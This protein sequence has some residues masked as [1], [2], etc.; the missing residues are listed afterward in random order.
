MMGQFRL[1]GDEMPD[2]PGMSAEQKSKMQNHFDSLPCFTEE[3]LSAIQGMLR[4][5]IDYITV[6]ELAVLKG[7]RLRGEIDKYIETHIFEDIKLPEMAK[8]L[9]RSIS[10]I[11]QFLRKNY[12]TTF[13][14]LV[15]ENRLQLAENY[16]RTHPHATV[17]EVAYSAGF[18]DQFYFSRVF[19]RLRGLPPGKFREQLRL[20]DPEKR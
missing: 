4:T 17:A 9:G 13:K 8:K 20:P 1:A 14:S 11:S 7:D 12:H 6:R 3:K 10:S 19:H 2:F 18:K 16:W 15:L 5:L